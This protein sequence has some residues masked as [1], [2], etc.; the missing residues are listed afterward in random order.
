MADLEIHRFTPDAA[1]DVRTSF[2]II[3]AVSAADAPWEHPWLF[4]QIESQLQQRNF[5]GFL[6]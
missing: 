3:N 2:E 1:E 5:E 4:E 6:R